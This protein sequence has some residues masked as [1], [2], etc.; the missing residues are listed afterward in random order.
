M[1]LLRERG[2]NVTTRD[3]ADAAGVAEGTLFRVFPDK[4]ALICAAIE[5]ALDPA[6][7]VAELRAVP[8]TTDLREAL[9]RAVEIMLERAREVGSLL[10]VLHEFRRQ[11]DGGHGEP[12]VGRARHHGAHRGPGAH[13]GRGGPHGPDGHRGPHPVETVIAAMTDLLRPHRDRLRHD[14]E[15]CARMLVALIMVSGRSMGFGQGLALSADQLTGLFLDGA[16][17]DP[18][19]RTESRP[20][21]RTDPPADSPTDSRTEETPC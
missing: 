11:D 3:L 21:A 12:A 16:L 17:V 8:A 13:Q 2:A 7:S 4:T 15:T 5:H 1:D 20:G 18:R 10:P 14:P 19:L 6:P 9:A